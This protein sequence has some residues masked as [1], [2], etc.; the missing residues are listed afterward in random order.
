MDER[1]RLIRQFDGAREQVRAALA[2]ID[3]RM[4]VNPRWSVKEL[5]AHLAGWDAVTGDAL[6]AHATGDLAETPAKGGINAYNARSVAARRGLSYEETVA[7]WEQASD[8]LRQALVDMPA[9]RLS[10]KM[11]FP[12]G[13]KGTVARAVAIMAGHEEEHAHELHVLRG[14]MEQAE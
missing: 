13:P 10:E 5:V 11:V 3:P 4:A 2:G 6:R 8:G 1:E 9:E 14:E 7:D 12:W